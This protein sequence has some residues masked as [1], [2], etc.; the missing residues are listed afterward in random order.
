M[1]YFGLVAE[2]KFGSLARIKNMFYAIFLLLQD[3]RWSIPF[4]PVQNS[5]YDCSMYNFV[6][7]YNL[8]L[9][10]YH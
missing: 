2:T 10:N 4:S 7:L 3:I 6:P 8:I 5:Q 9:A 1:Y